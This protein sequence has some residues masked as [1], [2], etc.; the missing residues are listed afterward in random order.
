MSAPLQIA[1]AI[2]AFVA[3]CW[4]IGYSLYWLFW[5]PAYHSVD[6]PCRRCRWDKALRLRAA[7]R[8][9]DMTEYKRLGTGR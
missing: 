8:R 6:C 5:Q 9:G 1:V 2:V 7:R 4:L 3:G